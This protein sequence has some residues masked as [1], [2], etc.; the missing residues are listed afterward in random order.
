LHRDL[1]S[2][3]IVVVETGNSSFNRDHYRLDLTTGA[4]EGPVRE[5]Y[6]DAVWNP[7]RQE[8]IAQNSSRLERYA[9][10]F[11]GTS[12]FL[13]E[14]EWGWHGTSVALS[15]DAT[16]LA[17][18]TYHL[19]GDSIAHYSSENLQTV[20]GVWPDADYPTG[21]AFDTT[22][23]MLAVSSD[24]RLQVFDVESH[25]RLHTFTVPSCPDG[26]LGDVGF[27]RG[28]ALA[29]VKQECGPSAE[30]VQFHWFRVD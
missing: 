10:D 16:Q 12:T 17:Y 3:L 23:A 6:P 19:D 2:R 20:V 8:L 9:I 25:E 4:L 29:F 5:S 15:A 24:V 21:M 11:T 28:G 18:G 26:Q 1:G 14:A 7:Q 22:G 27:S 13:E 30:S